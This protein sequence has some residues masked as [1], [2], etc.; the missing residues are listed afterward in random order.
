MSQIEPSMDSSNT[1]ANFSF[2]DSTITETEA[3]ADYMECITLLNELDAAVRDLELMGEYLRQLALN[4][5]TPPERRQQCVEDL[6]ML[7]KTVERTRRQALEWRLIVTEKEV[8]LLAP[9]AQSGLHA[10]DRAG[11]EADHIE[12]VNSTLTNSTCKKEK[13]IATCR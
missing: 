12:D 4:A 3:I 7:E 11:V 13:M 5:D 8:S 6:R 10:L 9:R 2:S 1:I